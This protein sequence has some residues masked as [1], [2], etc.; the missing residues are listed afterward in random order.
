M[1][2]SAWI[3]CPGCYSGPSAAGPESSPASPWY[4]L[5]E[6]AVLRSACGPAALP[7]SQTAGISLGNAG[8]RYGPENL[9]TGYHLTQIVFRALKAQAKKVT[10]TWTKMFFFCSHIYPSQPPLQPDCLSILTSIPPRLSTSSGLHLNKIVYLS[11]PPACIPKL[12]IYSRLCIYSTT[13]AQSW[14][15]DNTD[16]TIWPCFQATHLLVIALLLLYIPCF[17]TP[18]WHWHLNIFRICSCPWGSITWSHCREANKLSHAQLCLPLP[19]PPHLLPD[20]TG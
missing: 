13:Y 7:L 14:A 12:T 8:G 3:G 20:Q 16:T 6:G 11:Q 15:Y 2:T 10:C 4:S 18:S 17:Y 5:P 1:R 9:N 19:P